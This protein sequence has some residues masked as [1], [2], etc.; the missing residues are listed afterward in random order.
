M[1]TVN[2]VRQ[3]G[4]Y[5]ILAKTG[6]IVFDVS[7]GNTVYS[8]NSG[9]VT[10]YGSLDV[11]GTST[12]IESTATNIKDNIIFLNAGESNSYVSKGTSG[13]AIDRGS[14]TTL[15]NA[16]TL[17]YN[18]TSYWSFDNITNN[19]GVWELSSAKLTS[20]I[21]VNAIRVSGAQN[22]L[23]LFGKENPNAVLN[24]LGTTNYEDNVLDDDDIPNKKYVDAKAYA[25][26]EFT[27][28]IK[29]GKSFIEIRDNSINPVDPYYSATNKILGALGTT[30]NVVF[31][32]EG[33]SAS[34]QGL[35]ISDTNIL[36][37]SGRF[38]ETISITPQ[39]TG[40]VK[41]N[42]ALSLSNIIR[43][44]PIPYLTNVYSTSTVGGGGTGLYFVNTTRHDELVSRRRA[45]IYGIIF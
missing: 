5:Q 14:V 6:G 10:I 12:F 21:Q 7:N 13:I 2:I 25:G 33:T 31:K 39:N 16:A 35:T 43:P 40:T 8:A 37:N 11:I 15:D 20:A 17:L 18:D 24:V 32:F 36:V 19:R 9:T 44:D 22:T 3:S 29:V 28:K 4:D 42:S 34:L 38:S 41:I 45:I 27:K 1:A 30:T 26:E 23:N